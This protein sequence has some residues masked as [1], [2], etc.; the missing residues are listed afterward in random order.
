[1]GPIPACAGEP[2]SGAANARAARAYPR[3]RGGT[4]ASKSGNWSAVGLSP[5]ARGNLALMTSPTFLRGPIPACAGEPNSNST[6]FFPRGA[7]PRMRGGTV[8]SA[9][10][11]KR[12][13]GLSPHARGNRDQIV[14][15]DIWR[16]PIPACA[17]EP[18]GGRVCSRH[19]GAYPRMRGGTPAI[20]W[21]SGPVKG[22]SPHARGN[23]T[24]TR[25]RAA[26]RGPIPACAGEPLRTRAFVSSVRAYPRMRGGTWCC[27]PAP[28]WAWG[29]S[30]HARGNLAVKAHFSRWTG[31]IPACAGEP[32]GRVSRRQ[33]FGAYPRM[34]GGTV[35]RDSRPRWGGGLSPHARGNHVLLTFTLKP[36]GPIPACAGEPGHLTVHIDGAGAYPRMRGGTASVGHVETVGQGLSPHARGNLGCARLYAAFLGP[37]P[38]CAG[39]P[40]HPRPPPPWPRA[41]PRMRGGTYMNFLLGVFPWGLSPHARGNPVRLWQCQLVR[42]PIP[43]CAGEPR[44]ASSGSNWCWAYPRMRGGTTWAVTALFPWPGLS[45]HARG[46]LKMQP[47]NVAAQGPI[48]ACAGEPPNTTP[49]QC[50][51]RAYPRMRGGTM[52]IHSSPISITGL[53]PHA[54]GN[55]GGARC[56]HGRGGPIPACAGEP[57]GRSGCVKLSGAYPRMRGGT[58]PVI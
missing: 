47:M 24:S 55:L 44:S 42:G 38:A 6:R 4:I 35:R 21:P 1:M 29:L 15:P 17:G 36:Q 54:R 56:W 30:P 8:R 53:S 12:P 3:M 58:G 27:C 2:L 43:A 25:D 34:R 22:L 23:R 11:P 13:R 52:V 33:I 48:P 16:G 57:F 5:H 26:F 39:E 37:I 41:Y 51:H 46:N 50:L 45:P 7:Y 18:P 31:P 10:R 14:D 32:Q 20:T 49:K 9:K 40:S 28:C 19:R